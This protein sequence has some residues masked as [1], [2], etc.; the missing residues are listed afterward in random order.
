MRLARGACGAG[1]RNSRAG[2]R[3]SA[4]W[5]AGLGRGSG[6]RA[7]GVGRACTWGSRAERACGNAELAGGARGSAPWSAGL[8]RRSGELARGRRAHAGAWGSRGGVGLVRGACGAETRN[9]RAGAW[10]SAAGARGSCLE[11]AGRERGTRGRE[12]GARPLE[13]GALARV[14]LS[15]RWSLRRERALADRGV[16]PCPGHAARPQ[17]AGPL[18]RQPRPRAGGPHPPAR[19]A[20]AHGRGSSAGAPNCPRARGGVRRRPV[21]GCGGRPAGASRRRGGVCAI[22]GPRRPRR[23][24]R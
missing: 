23:S 12:R 21:R 20:L 1:T 19:A 5:S 9:S 7:A 16:G 17:G 8:G 3:G 2:A 11:R 15:R 18:A 24:A 6:E 4:P 13:R 14:G 10:G 22:R